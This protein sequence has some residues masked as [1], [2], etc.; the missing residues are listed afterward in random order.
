MD[1]KR[2]FEIKIRYGRRQEE[3]ATMILL[4]SKITDFTSIVTNSCYNTI[5]F[6]VKGTS[7]QIKTLLE[8]LCSLSEAQIIYIKRKWF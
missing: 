5:A 4:D 8:D 3:R 2:K 6:K 1:K 7:E